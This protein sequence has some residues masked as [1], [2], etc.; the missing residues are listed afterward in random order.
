MRQEIESHLLLEGFF[1]GTEVL[2]YYSMGIWV[3]GE[4]ITSRPH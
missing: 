1:G 3:S 4:V 2:V